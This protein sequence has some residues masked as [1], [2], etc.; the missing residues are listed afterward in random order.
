MGI[1]DIPGIS[2]AQADARYSP[3]ASFRQLGLFQGA[4]PVASHVFRV[5]NGAG[6]SNGTDTNATTG[7]RHKMAAAVADVRLVYANISNGNAG[8]NDI[9]VK[10]SV[11][12]S[13]V[14]L[15]VYFRG[16]RTA[17]VAPGAYL[18]SDPVALPPSVIAGFI[19][20]TRTFVSVAASGQKWPLGIVTANTDNE[21]VV[22]GSDVTDSGTI[23]N[24][25]ANA[26]GPMAIIGATTTP[27]PSVAIIGDSISDGQG[28]A[29]S[30]GAGTDP[31]FIQ[32]ALFNASI[33][34]VP[35]G[36][37]GERAD[38]FVQTANFSRRFP[39]VAAATDG[40]I[41]YGIN[42]VNA[43]IPLSTMQMNALTLWMATAGRGL[44]AWQTT[45]TPS[46]TSSN[47]VP[48]VNDANRTGFNDW[49]RDGA[50]I[51]SSTK[52]AVAVGT[53]GALRAGSTGHPLSGYFEI[54]DIAET[55]RNSGIWKDTYSSDGTHPVQ[56]G[57]IALSAGVIT[58]RFTA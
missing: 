53:T 8:P 33:G 40:V 30:Y 55:A 58:S 4:S 45:I 57:A 51:D 17:T 27:Q 16:Q 18:I 37:P 47:T 35:T 41:Q 31:G 39:V 29:S 32:R 26:F 20:R 28:D 36:K 22:A 19:L 9:N 48:A 24:A 2:R 25:F 44:R 21:G 23:T 1:L 52:T 11:D 7:L 38:Q 14:L 34:Y 43:A 5:G 54:A 10:A 6:L 42:D 56:A 13:G 3:R 46:S 12:V 49:I 15:P 50:P